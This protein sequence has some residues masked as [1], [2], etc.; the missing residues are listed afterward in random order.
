MRACIGV[1]PLEDY[2]HRSLV[3]GLSR[4]GYSCEFGRY[5]MGADLLVVW[6]PWNGSHRQMLQKHFAENGKPVIVMENGWLSPLRGTAYYQVALD[7][8]NGTGRFVAGDDSRWNDLQIFHAPW[9]DRQG[10]ILV[11]GQRGHPNDLRTAPLDW[12]MKLPVSSQNVIRRSRASLRPLA[13]DLSL[14]SVCHVWSS[15]AASHAVV[16][17]VP[18]IQHGPNLMVSAL[19][20]R[21]D[22]PLF[23][24][25]R[26]AELARLA[27]A[28]W[29]AVELESG[30]PFA[31]LL[32]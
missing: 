9:V 16:A 29:N 23:R 15:N 11:I 6:S 12:H 8:W 3:A 26:R 2:P 28:Q 20:S 10:P 24:G 17:G 1:P 4:L 32:R 27:W 14:A 30:E 25:E 18:V 5:S 13:A 31:R 19:A 21:P 7:G 22:S